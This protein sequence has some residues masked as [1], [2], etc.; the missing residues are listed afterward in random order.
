MNLYTGSQVS[1]VSTV[2]RW[3]ED[4]GQNI[5]TF[6]LLYIVGALMNKM[7]I[8]QFVSKQRALAIWLI[9]SLV[10]LGVYL[11]DERFTNDVYGS[12]SLFYHNPLVVL[13]AAS[14]FLFFKHIK[15]KSKLINSL[16]AAAFTCYLAHGHILKYLK[17]D[18]F[19]QGTPLMLILYYIVIAASIYLVSYILYLVYNF[20]TQRLFNK[21]DRVTITYY[22]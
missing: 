10:L 9:T 18:S 2:S 17:I 19:L 6:A 15:F 20:A 4:T 21:L 22:T 16:A 5:V 13:Q 12:V 3:H 11:L 7:Q 1:G 8:E 14:L